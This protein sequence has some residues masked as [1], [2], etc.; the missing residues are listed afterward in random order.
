MSDSPSFDAYRAALVR[1][2][3]HHVRLEMRVLDL[4]MLLSA[5]QLSLRHPRFP[6]SVR[7]YVEGFVSG[8]IDNLER[9]NPVLGR[10][11]RAGSD[12]NHDIPVE[13]EPPDA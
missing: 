2:Q 13:E 3:E 9:L 4:T 6:A 1:H 7:P 11:F 5:L 10:T 8:A 12:P